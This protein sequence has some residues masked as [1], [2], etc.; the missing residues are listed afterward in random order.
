MIYIRKFKK[1]IENHP[2]DRQAYRTG[3][4]IILK[5]NR[6]FYIDFAN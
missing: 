2:V 4:L 5:A 1:I 3:A 6:G